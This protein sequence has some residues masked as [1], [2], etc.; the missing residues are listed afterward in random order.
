M[1]LQ[2]ESYLRSLKGLAEKLSGSRGSVSGAGSAIIAVDATVTFGKFNKAECGLKV[3]SDTD[4]SR[5]GELRQMVEVSQSDSVAFATIDL[6]S[7]SG[8]G[9]VDAIVKFIKPIV[10]EVS[11]D[12]VQVKLHTTTDGRTQLVIAFALEGES[13]KGALVNTV[14]IWDQVK[15]DVDVDFDQTPRTE[16]PET[17]GVQ[18]RA[19]GS[20]PRGILDKYRK[21]IVKDTF[22]ARLLNLF[23]F[24]RFNI[25]LSPIDQILTNLFHEKKNLFKFRV[26]Y[27]HC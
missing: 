13:A 15:L 6:K 7:T 10:K 11:K 20:M 4:K 14:D 24:G 25:H 22:L 9:M 19:K 26:C 18:V 3:R 17:I 27:C 2:S 21:E 8:T 12:K 1:K 16:I 5:A 23:K